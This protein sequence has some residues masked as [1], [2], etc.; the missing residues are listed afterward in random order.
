MRPTEQ[1]D[2][3][4]GRKNVSLDDL[5]C[6]PRV[7][8]PLSSL[9]YGPRRP[10]CRKGEV[11]YINT[12]RTRT[13]YKVRWGDIRP[14][15][16]VWLEKFS[17]VSTSFTII[18]RDPFPKKKLRTLHEINSAT[19]RL[20]ANKNLPC[21]TLLFISTSSPTSLSTQTILAPMLSSSRL[22]RV[23]RDRLLHGFRSGAS[24]K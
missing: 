20:L 21:T 12:S 4:H 9:Q 14:P 18:I 6:V 23:I 19:G 17:A 8:E 11:L 2:L 16:L 5:I 10:S 3:P 24:T 22:P 7:L 1:V 15:S 13:I